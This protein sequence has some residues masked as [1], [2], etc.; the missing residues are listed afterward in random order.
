MHIRNSETQKTLLKSRAKRR[1]WVH[2]MITLKCDTTD[3]NTKKRTW[4]VTALE[5]SVEKTFCHWGFKP[6]SRMHQPHTCHPRASDISVYLLHFCYFH[7]STSDFASRQLSSRLYLLIR[8][9][10]N[11][12]YRIS[13]SGRIQ[14]QNSSCQMFFAVHKFWELNQLDSYQCLKART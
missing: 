8:L 9:D 1:S 12:N 7:W 11:F 13:S 14:K 3:N 10:F 2:H 6:G 4:G 5:Q